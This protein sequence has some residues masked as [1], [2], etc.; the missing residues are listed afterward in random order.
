MGMNSRFWALRFLASL[1]LVVGA[2]FGVIAV[3]LAAGI[4]VVWAGPVAGLAVYILVVAAFMAS[5]TRP[6]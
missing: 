2:F 3:H 6:T 5:I 1:G 4:A